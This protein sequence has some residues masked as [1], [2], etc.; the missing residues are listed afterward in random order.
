MVSPKERDRRSH[1]PRS[2]IIK[3]LRLHV[4]RSEALTPAMLNNSS[5]DGPFCLFSIRDSGFSI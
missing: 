2:L 1:I 3:T 5:F 4:S